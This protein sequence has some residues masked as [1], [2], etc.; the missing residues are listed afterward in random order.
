M[1]IQKCVK[2][3]IPR[4]QTDRHRPQ[5]RTS[6]VERRRHRAVGQAEWP[7]H[8]PSNERL[9]PAFGKRPEEEE[10][11]LFPCGGF[12]GEPRG[13]DPRVVEDQKIGGG[14]ML[15]DVGELRV[16]RPIRFAVV[17]EQTRLIADGRR[18]VGD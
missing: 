6:A 17:D 2:I 15:G 9:P 7:G 13:V 11:R 14:E 12:G 4:R 16:R 3:G 5:P 1:P 8:L 10:F 18:P